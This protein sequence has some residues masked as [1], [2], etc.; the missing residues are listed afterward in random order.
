MT[1]NTTS[2]PLEIGHGPMGVHTYLF[3]VSNT[4]QAGCHNKFL[5]SARLRRQAISH[6]IHMVIV[7]HLL[8]AAQKRN[9]L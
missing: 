8:P 2:I 5:V 6:G 3:N 9:I 4:T 7:T 1:K